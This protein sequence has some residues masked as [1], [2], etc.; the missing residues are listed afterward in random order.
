MLSHHISPGF[1]L[2]CFSWQLFLCFHLTKLKKKKEKKRLTLN[3]HLKN[4]KAFL[5]SYVSTIVRKN[6]YRRRELS[7]IPLVNKENLSQGEGEISSSTSLRLQDGDLLYCFAFFAEAFRIS[8]CPR[9]PGMPG[10]NLTLLI[11]Q[12]IFDLYW[13]F[14]FGKDLFLISYFFTVS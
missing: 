12:S 1:C 9:E 11:L 14:P 3:L 4:E 7:L 8:R 10:W 2:V 6:Q 5:N 13:I